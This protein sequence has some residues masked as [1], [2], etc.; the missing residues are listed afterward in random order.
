MLKTNIT[1]LIIT[2]LLLASSFLFS[3]ASQAQTD[4]FITVWQMPAGDL[5]LTF[6]SEGSYTIDWGDGTTEEV[7]DNPTHTYTTVGDYTVT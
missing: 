7:T 4:S 5:E 6:P 3:T 1:H 2:T